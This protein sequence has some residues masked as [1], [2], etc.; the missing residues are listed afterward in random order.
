MNRR[1]RKN[2][3]RMSNELE[4]VVTTCCGRSISWLGLLFSAHSGWR[5]RYI[6]NR[7]ISL[8][9][10][11]GPHAHLSV[12]DKGGNESTS[13]ALRQ[14]IEDAGMTFASSSLRV[15]PVL[16]SNG[17]EAHTIAH[18]I[19]ENHHQLAPI[20]TFIQGDPKSNHMLALL[21][22]YQALNA[23]AHEQ[24]PLAKQLQRSHLHGRDHRAIAIVQRVRELM[25]AA[26]GSTN[27]ASLCPVTPTPPLLCEAGSRSPDFRQWP[28]PSNFVELQKAARRP[29]HHMGGYTSL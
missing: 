8:A 17:R 23:S 1:P 13:H 16:N 18:H 24:K 3:L 6:G 22:L 14:Q 4:V 9:S 2:K 15:I 19:A 21:Y 29:L 10:L 20:T 12:Y 11:L 27:D 26:N 5:S 28:C 7:T 25:N